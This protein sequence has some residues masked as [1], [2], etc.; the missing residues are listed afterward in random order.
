MRQLRTY[1]DRKY[2]FVAEELLVPKFTGSQAP[3]WERP[4]LQAKAPLL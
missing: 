3:A 1:L 4:L 2:F